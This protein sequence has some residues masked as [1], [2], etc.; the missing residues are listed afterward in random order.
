[1]STHDLDL[2]LEM[3]RVL[4]IEDGKVA[5]DGGPAEAVAAYRALCTDGLQAQGPGSR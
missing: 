5:F 4:V 1:M 3:D 2:A